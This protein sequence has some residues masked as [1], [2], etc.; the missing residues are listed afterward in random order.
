MAVI[1]APSTMSP[2]RWVP[3]GMTTTVVPPMF[4]VPWHLISGGSTMATTGEPSSAST[5]G[6]G[7]GFKKWPNDPRLLDVRVRSANELVSQAVVQRTA[8]DIVEALRLAR[9]ASELD[10]ADTSVKR[11][12]EQYEAELAAFTTPPAPPLAKASSA[13]ATLPTVQP[14][15]VAAAAAPSATPHKIMLEANVVRPKLGQTVECTARVAPTK[16]SCQ[17]AMFNVTGPGLGGGVNMEAQTSAPGVF[18]V[19]YAFLVGG[20][21]DVT[22]TLQADGKGLRAGRSLVAG[23]QPSAP[24]A[25]DPASASSVKW[26]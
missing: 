17:H 25:P 23:E 12:V 10:P 20:R 18:K 22:F 15:A 4:M 8:G 6:G 14:S 3:S 9:A 11:L 5:G 21:F 13:P 19:S 24:K 16:G 7:G 26:M 2:T 1:F